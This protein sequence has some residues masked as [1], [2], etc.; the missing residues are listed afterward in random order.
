MSYQNVQNSEREESGA[1]FS[2][3]VYLLYYFVPQI[4]LFQ[5]GNWGAFNWSRKKFAP[6]AGQ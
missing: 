2:G 6:V 4:V 1:K 5:Y 3:F